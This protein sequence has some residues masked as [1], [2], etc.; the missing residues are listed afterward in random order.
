MFELI[1]KSEI[2][3][4]VLKWLHSIVWILKEWN[5]IKIL[6]Y[7]IYI[8]TFILLLLQFREYSYSILAF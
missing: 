3:W 6:S 7:S 1:G 8:F 2:E 4:Y 5:G